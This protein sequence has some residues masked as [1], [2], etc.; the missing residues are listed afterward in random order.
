MS[1]RQGE[2]LLICCYCGARSILPA[3]GA[4]RLVCLGCGAPIRQIAP[5]APGPG[6]KTKPGKRGKRPAVPHAADRPDHIRNADRPARR[7]K[8]KR[9]KTGF[10]RLWDTLE[11]L[12]EDTLEEAVDLFD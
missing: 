11:D 9:R 8:G 5:L 10:T 2:R 4:R 12:V 1:T 7:K 6:R 3:K